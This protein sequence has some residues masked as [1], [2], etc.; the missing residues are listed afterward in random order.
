MQIIVKYQNLDPLPQLCRICN[1][2]FTS[3]TYE[4]ALR[5]KIALDQ[6]GL[7]VEKLYLIGFHSQALEKMKWCDYWNWESFPNT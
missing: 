7:P 5:V 6:K 2:L 4:Y 1:A 3:L